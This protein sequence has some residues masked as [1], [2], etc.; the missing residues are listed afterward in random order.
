MALDNPASAWSCAVLLK[1][2]TWL[3]KFNMTA[4]LRQD[5]RFMRRWISA[6]CRK[7]ETDIVRHGKLLDKKRTRTSGQEEAKCETN[8]DMTIQ[9]Q[10]YCTTITGWYYGISLI[11]RFSVL[12]RLKK[13][14]T[15]HGVDIQERRF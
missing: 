4:A 7:V 6:L 3:P 10:H 15:D 5:G 14:S 2:S 11:A 9:L 12:R 8:N 1:R 13:E